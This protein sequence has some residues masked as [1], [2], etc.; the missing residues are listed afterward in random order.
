MTEKRHCQKNNEKKA[1]VIYIVKNKITNS[2][3]VVPQAATVRECLAAEELQIN[4]S[5]EPFDADR[6]YT[7]VSLY[8]KSENGGIQNGQ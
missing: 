8:I 3:I 5:E 2:V 4:G 1:K 7:F 6:W